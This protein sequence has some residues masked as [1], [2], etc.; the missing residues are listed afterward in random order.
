MSYIYLTKKRSKC[1]VK[2]PITYV[3]D[4]W[5]KIWGIYMSTSQTCYPWNSAAPVLN[6]SPKPSWRSEPLSVF[7]MGQGTKNPSPCRGMGQGTS[8]P[9]RQ[10]IHSP[11]AVYAM[12]LGSASTTMHSSNQQP[13]TWAPSTSIQQ[14]LSAFC[15][16]VVKVAFPRQNSSNW[17]N[18]LIGFHISTSLKF[19]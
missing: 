9:P 18:S 2:S 6:T 15:V 8:T 16:L 14:S 13:Q 10:S 1:Y 7:G 19:H 17:C 5:G 3:I 4:L 12:A 11:W